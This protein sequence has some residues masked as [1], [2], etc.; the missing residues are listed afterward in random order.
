MRFV[1]LLAL[2]AFVLA[3]SLLEAKTVPAS[4][5]QI[6]PA[7]PG[8]LLLRPTFCSCGVYWGTPKQ[9]SITLEFR[10]AGTQAWRQALPPHYYN[11]SS[12]YSGSIVK[13]KEDTDYEVT[14]VI[15][16]RHLCQ[17]QYQLPKQLPE[18]VD[19]SLEQYPSLNKISVW[20]DVYIL[21]GPIDQS[22]FALWPDAGL[23]VKIKG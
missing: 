21:R 14:D 20:D 11:E 5:E 6:A 18:I 3:P 17:I 8:E 16:S 7:K 1:S 19:I 15:L 10:K 23:V 13:L 12:Q 4:L 2:L 22:L 9:E